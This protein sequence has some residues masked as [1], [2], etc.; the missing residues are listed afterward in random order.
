MAGKA[1]GLIYSFENYSLDVDRQ[2]LRRGTDLVAIE[3]QVLDLLHY[4]IRNR[5]HVA[6]KDDL[7]THVWNGRIVS[8]STLTSRITAARHAVGDSG[9]NQRLIRTIARKGIRFVGDVRVSRDAPG[10]A[11]SATPAEV[12]SDK[13]SIA[14]LAF[15]NL[16]RDPSQQYFVDGIVEDIIT[17]LSHFRNLFVIARN[18]S[19]QYRHQAVDPKRIARELGVRYILEGSAREAGGRIRISAQLIDAATG[20]HV[21]ADRY[22]RE[23][24]DVFAVQD[25]VT[26][27]IAGALAVR[28]EANDLAL[29]KRKPPGS[30]RSYDYWLQGKKYLNLHSREGFAEAQRYFEHAI[31]V[32][33]SYARAYSSLAYVHKEA[34]SYSG[35]GGAPLAQVYETAYELAQRAMLLD[36]TDNMS[37]IVL[38]WCLMWRRRYSEATRAFERA[39]ALNSNDADAMAYR[40]YYLTIVGQPEE[41]VEALKT[42]TRLNPHH[43]NY[44]LGNLMC[45]NLMARRYEDAIS[46]VE[47]I[48]DVWPESPAWIACAF[49]H[50]GRLD[51]ARAC[52]AAF[53]ANIRSIWVGDPDAGP[54]EYV[55]W[56]LSDNPF[57]RQED[58]DFLMN[59]MRKAGLPA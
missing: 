12:A 58:Y 28:I 22:D 39:L 50:S 37:H 55:A 45:A 16:S 54:R 26:Q 18:S 49:A 8:E 10:A 23:L 5:E 56:W 27:R 3:P 31:E 43:P 30:M 14:V 44:Y 19:F 40:G 53:V 35:W 46:A 29:A 52:A 59:G 41:G 36:D 34:T 20:H 13:P 38:G 33:P 2:E 51:E 1:A 57:R 6:S 25:E 32:D 11:A 4:L 48:G 15:D 42:A 9:A 47:G 21:W 17:A 24:K 7:I